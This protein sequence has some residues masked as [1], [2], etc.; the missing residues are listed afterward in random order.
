VQKQKCFHMNGKEISFDEFNEMVKQRVKMMAGIDDVRGFELFTLLHML[1]NVSDTL[2]SQ[3]DGDRGVSSARACILMRL[4]VDDSMGIDS[5]LTPTEL[6][7]FQNVSKNT[8]SSLIRGLEDQ[9]LVTREL[10]QNDKRV[11]RLKITDSGRQLVRD[12]VPRK[13]QLMN[14]LTNGLSPA[15]LDQLLTLLQKLRGS[16]IMKVHENRK[17]KLTSENDRESPAF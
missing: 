17:K 8:I 14:T 9:G 13:A 5:S 7:R 3:N 10:D 2:T 12:F 16:L 1:A 15:E 11:F 6:S 4:F